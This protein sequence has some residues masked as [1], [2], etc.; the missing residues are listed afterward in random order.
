MIIANMASFPGR[1]GSTLER[2]VASIAH[3]V[4]VLNLC[5]NDYREIP[6]FLDSYPNVNA[7]LPEADYKDVGKFVYGTAEDDD[8][9]F[10]CD[11]DIAYAPDHVSY[12]QKLR[13][14]YA[15]LEPII[16]FHG[17]IYSDCFRGNHASRN[18]FSFRTRL[19]RHRVVN[20]L[21]TGTVHCKGYQVPSFEYMAGS[22]KFVDVRFAVRADEHGWPL[23]CGAR[24]AGWMTDLEPA[25]S[26][27][28][29]FTKN[30]PLQV[31]REVQ[32]VAGYGKLPLRAV[33]RVEVASG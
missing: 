15:S 22:E 24:E 31:T 16:G 12:C 14:A 9:V 10:Y 11:D 20:Q 32:R 27:F 25:E 21:G 29:G 26:I 28:D 5:L 1:S 33:A 7:F 30:W 23:I 18:V 4:D 6:G 3:Q 17:V 8:D 19:T 13:G 2:A